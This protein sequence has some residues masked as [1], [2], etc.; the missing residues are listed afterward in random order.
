MSWA[1]DLWGALT[2][3]GSDSFLETKDW[4]GVSGLHLTKCVLS[5]TKGL[6]SQL[7]TSGSYAHPTP[8]SPALRLC[9]HSVGATYS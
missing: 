4:S 1:Q 3:Q 6:K 2:P 8:I 7:D 9:R 5:W